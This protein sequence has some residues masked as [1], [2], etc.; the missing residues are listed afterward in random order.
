MLSDEE[1]KSIQE[2]AK[3][4]GTSVDAVREFGGFVAKCIDGPLEQVI[5]IWNDKLKYR[6]WKN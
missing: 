4:A 3:T 1:S 5:G 2:V 6:R